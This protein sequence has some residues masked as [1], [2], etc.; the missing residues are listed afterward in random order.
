MIV[1]DNAG[2]AFII[3]LIL[4][5]H[6]YQV[7]TARDGREGYLTYLL[8]RPDLVIADIQMPEMNGVQMMRLIRMHDSNVRTIYISGELDRF[9]SLL[10]E[11]KTRYEAVLLKKPFTK[12]EL[13]KS[14]SMPRHKHY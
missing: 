2:L 7:V 10:E 14:V 5:A 6:G 8:F 4:E 9:R 11:E 3:Q 12:T 1:D 13:I